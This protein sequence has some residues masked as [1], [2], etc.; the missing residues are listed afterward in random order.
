MQQHP[1]YGMACAALGA[2]VRYYRLG[3]GQDCAGHALVLLR[4]WPML[5]TFALMSRGPVFAHE[6][7]AAERREATRSLIRVLSR[8]YRGVM[9]T[10]ERIDGLDPLEVCGLLPMVSPGSVARLVLTGDAEHLRKRAHGK[11][12]NRLVRAEGAGLEVQIS[13]LP[14]QRDHWLLKAEMTQART[15]RYRRL[16]PEFTLAWAAR[17][18]REAT[19]LFTARHEGKIVAAM[20]FLTHGRSGNYHIGWSGDEGRKTHAHTLLLWKAAEWFAA[21]GYTSLD[22]GTLDTERSPG[23]AR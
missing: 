18:G 7:S 1:F 4:H 5:G 15:R 20:L 8:R 22:L 12:R 11:W 9:A 23:L 3:N 19:R 10:A 14:L 17:A 2:G 13:S 21:R 6:L 16:P